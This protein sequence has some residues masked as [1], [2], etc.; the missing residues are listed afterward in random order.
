MLYLFL[1]Y[2]LVSSAIFFSS[3]GTLSLTE[4][5]FAYLILFVI[6]LLPFVGFFLGRI[7]RKGQTFDLKWLVAFGVVLGL[8]ENAIYSIFDS[9]INDD[10]S[11]YFVFFVTLFL[12]LYKSQNKST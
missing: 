9:N 10:F 3:V 5:A 12:G 1:G 6:E 4:M 7:I 2:F 8:V 11:M